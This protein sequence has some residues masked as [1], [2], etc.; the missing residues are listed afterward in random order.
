[1]FLVFFIP[2]KLSE[3]CKYQLLSAALGNPGGAGAVSLLTRFAIKKTGSYV[4]WRGEEK[5]VARL[6]PE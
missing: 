3:V 2:I 1:M 5:R 4:Q 6:C